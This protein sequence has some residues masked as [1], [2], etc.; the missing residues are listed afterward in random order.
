MLVKISPRAAVPCLSLLVLS[1]VACGHKAEAPPPPCEGVPP[2]TLRFQTAAKVNLGE[3]GESLATTLRVFLLRSD[4][5]LLEATFDDLLDRPQET[6]GDTLL[7]SD[8]LALFPDSAE[9]RTMKRTP[10]AAAVAVVA[11][12]REPAGSFWRGVRRLPPPD[13]DHCRKPSPAPLTVRLEE[14]RLELR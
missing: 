6:L 12:F 9:T 7:A 4:G 5:K 10:D 2:V 8:E 14:N 3:K 11:L 1:A 13:P